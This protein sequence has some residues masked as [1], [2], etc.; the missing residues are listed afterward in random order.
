MPSTKHHAHD[1]RHDTHLLDVERDRVDGAASADARGHGAR[2]Q[3][4]LDDPRV[5]LQQLGDNVQL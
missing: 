2:D 4:V 3:G 1:Q 5:L